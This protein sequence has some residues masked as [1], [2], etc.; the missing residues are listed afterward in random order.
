MEF[1]WRDQVQNGRR[2]YM[3]NEKNEKKSLVKTNA[4]KKKWMYTDIPVL[5]L[6][7]ATN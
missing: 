6:S 1:I 3:Y 2:L 4:R 7:F 5:S